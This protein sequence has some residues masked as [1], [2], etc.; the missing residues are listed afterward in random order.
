MAFL[1]GAGAIAMS[2]GAAEVAFREILYTVERLAA[3]NEKLRIINDLFQGMARLDQLQRLQALQNPKAPTS[4]FLSESEHLY[5]SLDTLRGLVYNPVQESRIDSMQNILQRRDKQFVRYLEIRAELLNN[6]GLSRQIKS[7]YS[8]VNHASNKVDTSIIT[9]RQKVTTITVPPDTAARV[10]KPAPKSNIIDRIFN[11]KK[12]SAKSKPMPWHR[13]VQEEYSVKVDTLA[14]T[15]HDSI[16]VVVNKV[17]HTI[18]N[19]QKQKGEELVNRELDLLNSANM[20]NNQML[21]ILQVLQEDELEQAENNTI[22]ATAAVN[23]SIDR[24][25]VI[26]ILF[27]LGA[28]VLVYFIFI[29]IARS[30]RYRKQ[31]VEAKE[32]A[33]HLG[34]VKQRFLSNISHELRTPL[35]SILGYSEQVLKEEKAQ[36]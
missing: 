18:Q 15:K 25:Q 17:M 16:A 28:A 1:L 20:L 13:T 3:P 8:W 11:K 19:E 9:T 31:L 7:L 33:E 29:D 23:T 30:N 6:E 22:Q 26:S 32:E 14:L 12:P 5:L 24:I 34:Q 36:A 27:F 10:P 4:T 2:W 35:Q 21:S